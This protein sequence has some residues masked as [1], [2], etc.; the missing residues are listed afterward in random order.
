MHRVS[1]F[2]KD[3]LILSF[4]RYRLLIFYEDEIGDIDSNCSPKSQLRSYSLSTWACRL[5]FF[6]C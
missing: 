4:W 3:H 6:S 2:R 5:N 1:N